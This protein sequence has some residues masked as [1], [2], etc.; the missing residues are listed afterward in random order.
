MALVN[1]VGQ[2]VLQGLLGNFTNAHDGP[3]D[4]E[5]GT[6]GVGVEGDEDEIIE[7][8]GDDAQQEIA[9]VALRLFEHKETVLKGD[10]TFSYWP[11]IAIWGC[12]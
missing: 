5:V 1:L 6:S 10:E 4:A 8:L 12:L 9:A 7:I 11:S 3:I 2:L